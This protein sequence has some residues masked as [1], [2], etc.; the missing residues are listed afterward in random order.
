MIILFSAKERIQ[1]TRDQN[2]KLD[3]RMVEG[4]RTQFSEEIETD[5]RIKPAIALGVSVGRVRRGAVSG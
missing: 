4:A 5:S 3:L 1:P 2:L